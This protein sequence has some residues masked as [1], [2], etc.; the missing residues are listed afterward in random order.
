MAFTEVTSTGWFGR[1]G[2]SI[3]GILFGIVLVLAALVLMV[4]NEKNA[5]NDIRANKELAGKVVSISSAG[6]EPGNEGKLVHLNGA[7]KTQDLVRHDAFDIEENAIRLSWKSEIYQW[8][9]D[10]ETSTKKK[11]G[12]GKET[13][14]TYSY[15]KK[16]VANPVNSSGFK[17]SGHDNR[18]EPR[19]S[20]GSSNAKKVTIGAFKLAH[21]P[22]S[23]RDSLAVGWSRLLRDAHHQTAEGKEAV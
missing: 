12:G 2:E 14:K 22:P 6:V 9:E 21:L 16:W 1:I 8:V 23:G 15:E 20:S 4:W 3:K 19:F 18:G 11:L 7:A 13:V 5:V 10:E 17:E